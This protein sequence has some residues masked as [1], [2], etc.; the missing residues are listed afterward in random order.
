[1]TTDTLEQT[2]LWFQKAFRN[3]WTNKNV[4][5]QVGV[6]FEEVAEMVASLDS[7]DI[8]TVTAMKT[9]ENALKHLSRLLKER[10]EL[11]IGDPLEFLDS[12]A[13]QFVTG[14]GSGFLANMDTV[15]AL[16]E[17]NASNHSKFVDGEPIFDSNLK[18]QKGPDYF[19]PDLS[20][21][22]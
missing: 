13:D 1:M 18:I 14:V 15:G 9:A 16:K 6:H 7:K 19:K 11:I 12:I 4:S 8:E 2:R 21:F 22:I 20:K 5:T 3:G 17:V 10:N